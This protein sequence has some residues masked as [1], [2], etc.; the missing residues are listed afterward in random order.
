MQEQGGLD[1]VV[2]WSLDNKMVLHQDKFEVMNFCLNNSFLRNLPFTAELRQYTTPDGNI[3]EPTTSVRDL[4]IYI[5]DDYSWSL[6]VNNVVTDA[7]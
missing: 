5:S 4:G 1:R 7:R 3:L 2:K 6:Q